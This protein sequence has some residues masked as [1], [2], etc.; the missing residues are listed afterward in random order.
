MQ[1]SKISKFS[2]N[3]FFSSKK[4]VCTWNVPIDLKIRFWIRKFE[5]RW[6]EIYIFS[7][8]HLENIR[9]FFVSILSQTGFDYFGTIRF[10]TEQA[11]L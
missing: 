4:Y 2:W 8:L 11:L 3:L 7:I 10:N 6:S 5:N 9:F 1:P